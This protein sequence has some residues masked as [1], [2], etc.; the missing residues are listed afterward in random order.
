MQ[1]LLVDVAA[2]ARESCARNTT[3]GG[4]QHNEATLRT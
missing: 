1:L 2:D 4:Q 3:H